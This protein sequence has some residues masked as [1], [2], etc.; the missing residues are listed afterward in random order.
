MLLIESSGVP[1]IFFRRV[2]G[3]K[4]FLIGCLAEEMVAPHPDS[5]FLELRIQKRVRSGAKRAGIRGA[6]SIIVRRRGASRR[7]LEKPPAPGGGGGGG[8]KVEGLKGGL[9]GA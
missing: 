7:G 9:K 6:C 5:L 1:A 2:Q 8:Q 4:H 3:R